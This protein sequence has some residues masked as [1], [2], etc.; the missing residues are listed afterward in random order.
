MFFTFVQLL[1]KLFIKQISLYFTDSFIS[2]YVTMKQLF[3]YIKNLLYLSLV[4]LFESDIM[5]I[6][7]EA[8]SADI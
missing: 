3:T 4:Q 7:S 5:R 1:L 8:L 2:V 6:L